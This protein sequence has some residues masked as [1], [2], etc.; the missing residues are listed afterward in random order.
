MPLAPPSHAGEDAT[1]PLVVR[2]FLYHLDAN[3]FALAALVRATLDPAGEELRGEHEI[4]FR[5][6]SAD[7]HAAMARAIAVLDRFAPCW[8]DLVK[9]DRLN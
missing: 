5:R 8:R 6:T 4:I 1:P 2:V 7:P 9:V 3:A